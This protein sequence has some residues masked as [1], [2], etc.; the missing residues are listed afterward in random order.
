LRS[1]LPFS[2]LL[3]FQKPDKR[4]ATHLAAGRQLG[5]LRV[6]LR[7]LLQL[8][9]GHLPDQEV[10]ERLGDIATRKAEID[11]TSPGTAERHFRRAQEKVGR[12]DFDDD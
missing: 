1:L 9:L 4:A 5:A 7:Q 12:G 6:E 10:R 3:T 2:A 11:S 8:D